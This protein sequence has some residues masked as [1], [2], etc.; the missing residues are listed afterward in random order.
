[1]LKKA[2]S[3]TLIIT[4]FSFQLMSQSIPDSLMFK[5]GVFK[6]WFESKTLQRYYDSI[7]MVMPIATFFFLKGN[8]LDEFYAVTAKHV[9]Q[10]D[11]N[12]ARH[13]RMVFHSKNGIESFTWAISTKHST[14]ISFHS[15][16]LIDLA[17]ICADFLKYYNG[18]NWFRESDILMKSELEKVK[19]GD[20]VQF[21][22]LYPDSVKSKDIWYWSPAG[23][24]VGINNP[25]VL[26]RDPHTGFL[27]KEEIT[28]K[29]KEKPGISGSP[30]FIN[31][32]GKWKII[33][34]INCGD[35]EYVRCT[36][37][38]KILDAIATSKIYYQWWKH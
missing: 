8:K 6:N 12:T 10:F 16:S 36:P 21:I 23:T 15:D 37:G 29:I 18:T 14:A 7:G 22:G 32:H 20:T 13:L 19:V 25:P 28:I 17:L 24:F 9:I 30:V 11:S 38:Y 5:V 1:M 4:V 3:T 27:S 26:N 34:V 33:G 2:L 31:Y 35:N